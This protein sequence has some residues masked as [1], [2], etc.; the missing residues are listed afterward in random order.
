[1]ALVFLTQ[2]WV[3]KGYLISWTSKAQSHEEAIA[4]SK[5]LLGQLVVWAIAM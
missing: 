1:M 2:F 4:P 5:I 3:H